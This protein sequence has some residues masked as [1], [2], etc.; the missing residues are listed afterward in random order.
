[1]K[2]VSE[3]QIKLFMCLLMTLDSIS[4]FL[5]PNMAVLYHLLSRPVAG[6]F[7]FTSVEGLKHTSNVGRYLVRLYGFAGIMFLGSMIINTGF[8][9]AEKPLGD[10]AFITIAFGVSSIALFQ[11]AKGMG[12]GQR[13][14]RILGA[15]V[16]ALLGLVCQYGYIMIPAMLLILWSGEKEKR[17]DGALIVLSMILLLSDFGWGSGYSSLVDHIIFKGNFLFVLV[18][19]F[20][21]MYNGKREKRNVITKYFFYLYYPMHIWLIAIFANL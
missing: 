8:G 6:W 11:Q 14:G 4:R 3:N 12:A 21:H 9:M 13:A 1:M 18:I 16:L 19:P 20:I 5:P 2:R 17:R 7:A 10:N 15:S